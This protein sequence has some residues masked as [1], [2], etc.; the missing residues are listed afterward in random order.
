[1]F[2]AR[3]SSRREEIKSLQDAVTALHD[4]NQRAY[5][6]IQRLEDDKVIL[7][8]RLDLVESDKDRLIDVVRKLRRK[9]LDLGG[10]VSDIDFDFGSSK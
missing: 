4:Q 10:D 9:I 2:S 8:S 7:N 6:R 3:A 5:D 1:M